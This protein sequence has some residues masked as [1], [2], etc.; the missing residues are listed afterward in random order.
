MSETAFSSRRD[1]LEALLPFFLNGTLSGSDLREV[2][3]WLAADPQAM[4]SLAEVEA[5]HSATT[6]ANEAIRPPADALARFSAALEGEAG[7]A[8]APS[9]S[10]RERLARLLPSAPIQAAWIAA[11]LALAILAG[12]TL[13]LGMKSAE[14]YSVAGTDRAQAPFV[15]VAFSAGASMAQVSAV[16]GASGLEIDAGPLPGGLYRVLVPAETVAQYEA[17][18]AGLEK[19]GIV[20][21]VVT[22]RKPA[23]D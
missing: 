10:L 23:D 15:L 9:P 3:E 4:A 12:Q 6:R 18:I 7:K 2:E 11:G 21:T 5:E 20:E 17:V 1:R 8:R 14:Q 13:W 16:L 19:A 22:G